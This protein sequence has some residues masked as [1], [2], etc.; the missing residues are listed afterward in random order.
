M[1]E[2]RREPNRPPSFCSKGPI[3]AEQTIGAKHS[4]HGVGARCDAKIMIDVQAKE[5]TGADHVDP[6]SQLLRHCQGPRDPEVDEIEN[7]LSF[8]S[9]ETDVFTPMLMGH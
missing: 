1:V 3:R 7:L 8:V 6:E 2:V 4:T 5:K 9:V